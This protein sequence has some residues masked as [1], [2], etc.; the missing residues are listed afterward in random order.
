MRKAKKFFYRRV[1]HFLSYWEI[2]LKMKC[3]YRHIGRSSIF[4][5]LENGTL[6]DIKVITKSIYWYRNKW[7]MLT[8]KELDLVKYINKP[9]HPH[10]W[11]PLLFDGKEQFKQFKRDFDNYFSYNERRNRAVKKYMVYRIKARDGK[12]CLKCGCSDNLQIDHIIPVR[13]GG[14]NREDNLQTLC[15]KCNLI[16]MTKIEDYRPKEISIKYKSI[17]YLMELYGA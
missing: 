13:L 14:D 2:E 16:K 1:K 3:G 8:P 10:L 15:Q 9:S 4:K 11:Y 7:D 6:N 12:K 17:D 5:N